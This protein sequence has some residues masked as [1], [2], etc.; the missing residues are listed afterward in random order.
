MGT[1]RIRIL[2]SLS[3]VATGGVERRRLSLAKYLDGARFEQMLMA[4]AATGQL[5][6]QLESAGTRVQIVGSGGLFDLRAMA[7]AV[8]VAREFRPHIVHGAVFEGLGVALAAGRSCGALVVLEET[9]HATNRSW[10]GHAVFR[11]LASLSDSCVAISPAVGRYLA[12]VTRVPAKHVHVI[13]NG[14]D[15]PVA[16]PGFERRAFRASLGIDA[17]AFVIGTVG[18]L[19]DD[20]HKRVSDLLRAMPRVLAERPS[21]T[22]LVVGEGRAK[23]ELEQLAR[24]LGLS[25]RVVFT[26][27]R[28]DTGALY[29]AMDLFTLVSSREGFGLVLPEAMLCRLAVVATRVGGICDIVVDGETGLLVPPRDPT[30]IAEALARLMGD[31]ELR[32]R[33]GEAGEARARARFG[34]SRYAADVEAFYTQLMKTK[35]GWR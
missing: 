20:D 31:A 22:L 14:V 6:G 34:A 15:E 3:A 30:A 5:V 11:T 19:V 18:R 35:R 1:N 26:G 2:H 27:H 16:P 29:R 13:P 23:P 33:F 12:E 21:A 25:S 7:R 24:D 10:R 17:D 9:S 32:T 4:R 28:D 8:R